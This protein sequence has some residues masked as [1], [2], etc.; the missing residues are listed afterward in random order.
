[1]INIGS[2]KER[3]IKSYAEFISKKL[4][5]NLKIKFDNNKLFDGTPRKILDCKVAKSYGWKKIISLDDGFKIAYKD[6][7]KKFNYL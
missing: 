2:E 1:M 5:F 3:S 6:F 4:K 7:L